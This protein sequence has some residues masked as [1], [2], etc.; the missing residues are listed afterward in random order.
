M[1]NYGIIGNSTNTLLLLV[2]F[3]SIY[4]T[5]FIRIFSDYYFYGVIIDDSDIINEANEIV[6]VVFLQ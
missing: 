1:C 2:L 5:I 3:N 6:A 4:K